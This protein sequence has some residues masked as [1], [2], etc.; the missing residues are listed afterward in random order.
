MVVSALSVVYFQA[1]SLYQICLLFLSMGLPLDCDRSPSDLTSYLLRDMMSS[2]HDP[3]FPFVWTGFD[4]EIA[5]I[6]VIIDMQGLPQICIQLL[7]LLKDL[8]FIWP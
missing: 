8:I 2:L 1:C 4:N 7:S 3:T 5:R 6:A